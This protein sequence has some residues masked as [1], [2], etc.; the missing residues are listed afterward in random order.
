MH[1]KHGDESLPGVAHE[2]YVD[3]HDSKLCYTDTAHY[4]SKWLPKH[5]LALLLISVDFEFKSRSNQ[6][7]HPSTRITDSPLAATHTGESILLRSGLHAGNTMQYG[8]AKT[9]FSYARISIIA[10]NRIRHHAVWKVIST[11]NCV[12]GK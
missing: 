7:Q 5:A 1:S 6:N 10:R 11:K 9:I 3:E 4:S 12:I 8:S 2:G